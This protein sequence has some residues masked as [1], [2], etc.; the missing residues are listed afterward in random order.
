MIKSAKSV[1]FLA[2]AAALAFA[3][4][5]R[6]ATAP[7]PA[8]QLL[9]ISTRGFVGT[10]DDVL[11]GGVIITGSVSKRVLLRGLGPSLTDAGLS[12]VLADPMLEL[13]D[14]NGNLII[15]NDD[16]EDT[17]PDQIDDTGIAPEDAREA[18]IIGDL[19]APDRYTAILRGSGNGTGV[20]LIEVYDLSPNSGSLLANISTRGF[21]EAEDRALI[22]GFIVG[23][24]T[25]DGRVIVRAISPSLG[26]EDVENPLA[27]PV[28]QLHSSANGSV[29]AENDNWKQTQR[30]L[31]EQTGVPPP[32][33]LESAIVAELPAGAYTALIRGQSGAVGTALVE[34]YDL[35]GSSTPAATFSFE[36]GLDGWTPKATDVSEPPIYWAVVQSEDRATHGSGS[37]KFEADNMTDAAKVWI[38]RA[39]SVRP[40][41]PY[42]VNVQFS[43]A[44]A[45]YGDLN[46]WTIIAGVRTAPAETRD[47]LTYQ[48]TTANGEPTNTGFKWLEKSYDFDVTS[49]ADGTLY[50]DVGVWGTW[51]TFRTYYI[52]DL[53]VTITEQ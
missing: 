14:Q 30:S 24:A 53:H 52:D 26:D 39:F 42:R 38:E 46:H 29:I 11:I 21:V 51:E 22:G 31:I 19:L 40:N 34:V 48:G 20:G 49:A 13:R 10:G 1:V 15:A 12:D 16:W 3:N 18:A 44:T 32:H 2:L 17:Q 43:F 7:D 47:D 45:D 8:A 36:N 33:D 35:A 41:R 50:I 6:A 37:A 9:N 5:T 25:T 27:D 28:L 23:G 4:S